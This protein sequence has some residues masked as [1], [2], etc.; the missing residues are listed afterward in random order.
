MENYK[1]LPFELQVKIAE[2]VPGLDFVNLYHADPELREYYSVGDRLDQFLDPYMSNDYNNNIVFGNIPHGK[3]SILGGLLVL[4]Y[5]LG[6][7]EY[8]TIHIDLKY[9]PYGLNDKDTLSINLSPLK[10]HL[11]HPS[12]IFILQNKY[13]SV[14]DGTYKLKSET[15]NFEI[16][17]TI[18]NGKAEGPWYIYRESKLL[19]YGTY[20]NNRMNGLWTFINNETSY[21]SKYN[22]DGYVASYKVIEGG[23][24]VYETDLKTGTAYVY[25]DEYVIYE[26]QKG[27]IKNKFREGR[28]IT[29][30]TDNNIT[31]KIT[32][33]HGKRNGLSEIYEENSIKSKVFYKNNNKEGEETIYEDGNVKMINTYKHDKL[34][35]SIEY[36]PSGALKSITEVDY[37]SL[38]KRLSK[39]MEYREDSTLESEYTKRDGKKSGQEIKYYQNGN[40]ESIIFYTNGKILGTYQIYYPDGQIKIDTL[41]DENKFIGEYKEYYSNGHIKTFKNYSGG[42]LDGEVISYNKDGSIEKKEKYRDGYI[43]R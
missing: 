19:A 38:S 42:R 26:I 8:I 12:N 33:N 29:Y 31:E 34:R 24:L 10:F 11:E 22:I 16:E 14:L 13:I 15:K 6:K 37:I 32:Y 4:N 7:L 28:W 18:K 9:I 1:N 40:V 2:S 5:I 25:E 30:D 21:I 23:I 3:H 35:G 43:V 20:N 17:V 41:K 39:I 36:Y 27:G